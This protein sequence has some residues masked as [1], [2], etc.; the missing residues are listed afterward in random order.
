MIQLIIKSLTL[1]PVNNLIIITMKRLIF[2]FTLVMLTACL[3]SAQQKDAQKEAAFAV[4]GESIHDFGTINE[5][6]GAASHTFK[7]KNE[8]QMPLVISNVNP[9]CGCTSRE[10]TKEPIAP[11]KTGDIT[12][13]YDPAGRPGPFTKTI[14]VFSNGYTG[15]YV[16]TIKGTVETKK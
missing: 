7:V 8:G 1:R 13:T 10:W 3:A 5:S 12:V 11:G 6:D 4:V 15:S 9:S 14:S 2:L 16:L